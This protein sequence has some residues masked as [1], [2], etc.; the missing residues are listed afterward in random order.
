MAQRKGFGRARRVVEYDGVALDFDQSAYPRVWSPSIDTL[1][2][3]RAVRAL[4]HALGPVRAGLEIGCGSG[5]LL[6][7]IHIS[8]PTRPY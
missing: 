6:S 7:L 3:C 5:Y 1:L 8:E 2:V 4:L